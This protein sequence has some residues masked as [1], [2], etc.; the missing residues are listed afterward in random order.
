VFESVGKGCLQLNNPG[1]VR[2][3]MAEKGGEHPLSGASSSRRKGDKWAK[4]PT[5]QREAEGE[6]G[7]EKYRCETE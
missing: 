3:R 7:V 5:R 1:D 4:K 2:D 6:G